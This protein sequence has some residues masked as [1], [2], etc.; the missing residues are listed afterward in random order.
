MARVTIATR[1][2]EDDTDAQRRCAATGGHDFSRS[3][4]VQE[5]AWGMVTRRQYYCS[6]CGK[7]K[8]KKRGA[9]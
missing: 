6:F 4:T 8:P 2:D 5:D 1:I 9:A 7:D 3:Y